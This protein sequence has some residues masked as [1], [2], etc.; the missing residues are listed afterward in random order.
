MS[1]GLF[2]HGNNHGRGST[3]GD[4]VG[5]IIK[6]HYPRRLSLHLSFECEKGPGPFLPAKLLTD[7]SLRVILECW[8]GSC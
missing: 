2:N 3:L 1:V 6:T 5:N 4:C 8:H 7:K